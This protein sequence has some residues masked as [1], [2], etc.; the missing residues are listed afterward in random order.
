MRIII[1]SMPGKMK[2]SRV[3][4][5]AVSDDLGHVARHVVRTESNSYEPRRGISTA[6]AESLKPKT[7]KKYMSAVGRCSKFVLTLENDQLVRLQLGPIKSR[8]TTN[9][10]YPPQL[11]STSVFK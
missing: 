4:C 9:L 6:S 11:G 1:K 7:I 8:V 10:Q 5:F 3:M 2:H